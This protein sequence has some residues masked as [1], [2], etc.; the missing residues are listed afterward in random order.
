[1]SQSCRIFR[2]WNSSCKHTCFTFLLLFSLLKPFHLFLFS[3]QLPFCLFSRC[4]RLFSHF[5]RF[6]VRCKS[7]LFFLFFVFILF[8]C[9]I[10][11]VF[12]V[13][14]HSV[15]SRG[16][17]TWRDLFCLLFLRLFLLDFQ[18]NNFP[19]WILLRIDIWG[20]CALF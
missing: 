16:C 9:F 18:L 7:Q 19:F 14:F 1:M 17:C 2:F 3:F 6:D 20:K 10:S 15:K 12:L 13:L 5:L 8:F 4:S 11:L